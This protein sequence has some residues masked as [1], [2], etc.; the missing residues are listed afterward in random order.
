[1][2]SLKKTNIYKHR[3]HF[4]WKFIKENQKILDIGNIGFL[5]GKIHKNSYF[6]ETFKRFK[7]TKFYG[8]DL[9]LPPDN[10]PQYINQIQHDVNTG[11]PYENKSF[12]LIYL[13]KQFIMSRLK[14]VVNA[15]LKI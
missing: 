13:V 6:S 5:N 15:L 7:K 10:S 11:I 2:I 3:K 8:I 9:E 12:D 1:M 14:A 4:L